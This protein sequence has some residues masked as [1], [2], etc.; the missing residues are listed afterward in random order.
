MPS[1]LLPKPPNIFDGPK[2]PKPYAPPEMREFGD[3]LATRQY[4]YDDALSAA[5]AF[6][7]ISDDRYTLRLRD[8]DYTDPER[9]T[10]RQRKE[11]VLTG[12]TLS[13]RMSGVWDLL[14]NATGKVLESR[15]QVVGRVPYLTSMGTFTFRG[16]DYTVN[17][18]Q[19]L[20]P[21]IFARKKNNG[22]LESYVNVLPGHGVSHRYSLDPKRGVFKISM[23]QAEMPLMPLL[24]LLGTTDKEFVD[25]WG[26]ALYHANY[27]AD[28]A[29]T[30][31]KLKER[32]LPFADRNDPHESSWRKK[33]IA[34]IERMQLDPDVTTATLG[35][36]YNVLNRDAILAATK[37]LLDI[38]A[39]KADVDDRDNMAYQKV[40]G[41]EDFIAERI[42]RDHGRIQKQAFRQIAQ[43]G[44]L[45]KMPSGLF[46]PQIEH[47]LI[48]SGLGQ[49]L[50]EI[51]PAEVFDRQTRITRLGEGG[52]PSIESIP[53]ESRN[54]QPSHLGYVD[55][56]RTPESMRAGIDI[57][58]ARTARK[59]RDGKVYSLFRNQKTGKDEWVSP[60]QLA[61]GVVATTDALKWDTKRIPVIN[62]GR[63]DYVTKNE[64]DYVFPHF[65]NTFS[66]LGNLIPIKSAVKGQRMSMASRMLTQ[67]LPLVKPE[68]PLVRGALPERPT[69][70][71]E[72][73]FGSRMGAVRATAGGR[74]VA[75]SPGS[76]KVRYDDGRS[77]EIELY[78]NHPFN[79]KTFIHQQPL[80][81]PGQTFAPGQL[82]ARS[83]FTDDSGVAAL[84]LNLRT[85][86]WPW[87]G[88]NYEDAV[89]ISE[90]AAKKMASE[91]M[92]VH[93]V[94][95]SDKHRMGRNSYLRL[96]PQK[97]D[98]ATLSKMDEKGVV[99]VGET[100]N[101]GDP[102]ILAARERDRA[103]N[104][105]HKKRQPGYVDSTQVWNHHDS[106]VVTDVVWGKK[107]PVVVVK[108][109][110]EMQPGD[111]LSGRYG[112]KGVVAA[113]IPDGQMPHDDQN[114]PFE[115]LLNPNGLNSRTN[116]AQKTELWLG[117]IA[118][119][120]GKPYNFNDFEDVDDAVEYA[121]SELRNHGLSDT[122]DLFDPVRQ[123]R[124]KAS[125]TGTR[126]FMK[127][128]HTA[129]SKE[130]GRST[131]GYTN[132]DAPA[133][134]GE[135]GCF[136]GDTA[137]DFFRPSDG[138]VA[139]VDIE[140]VVTQRMPLAIPS[141][142]QHGDPVRDE[143]V[144]WFRYEVPPTEV[145]EIEIGDGSGTIRL[146][147][148]RNHEMILSDGRT[149]LAG[150]LQPG[151]E[152]ME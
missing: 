97:Y 79:R 89:V 103:Q 77:E 110:S 19:R 15:K 26:S 14:D 37:K 81:Q 95:V 36:P 51:N 39:G 58:M 115:I 146:C 48:G 142:D 127:L 63:H 1:L 73:E 126:F 98:R 32:L 121:R 74:V 148:T 102:L 65:E 9:F 52:I 138:A 68:A 92:Y 80:V 117:K 45:G 21:G 152:L 82:L 17:H 136:T 5:R 7:P 20:L 75:A 76:L 137:I 13:R 46:T 66:A 47:V 35:K 84:G 122:E 116:P 94:E 139:R 118:A 43:A 150:E 10:R 124:L 109:V 108:S 119:Q 100:V 67:A 91:H 85:A 2:P 25:N 104:K 72:E 83:N 145:I 134:G 135:S 106:G 41:P 62:R 143:I 28:D 147:P 128:H 111:K 11:A 12:G 3:P 57:H 53:D 40:F 114:R 30:L 86:Y 113:I 69:T 130:Q 56:L 54:V 141:R 44:S 88:Y 125:A 112:D 96:F 107:G 55:P 61:A 27:A 29:G 71:F 38:Q 123:R 49:A 131:G 16:N 59:G 50:E 132:E 105:I 34:S 18:Q 8:V 149:V 101:Y 129:E 64:V 120:N 24:R 22:E 4:I 31:K 60:Q 78:D 140:A 87:Y 70:S 151:D 33:L 6:Q 144:D 90:S 93:D 133:K 23:G 99:R 42:R